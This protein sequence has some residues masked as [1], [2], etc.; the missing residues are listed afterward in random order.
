L[1]YKLDQ[2]DCGLP[3]ERRLAVPRDLGGLDV[4]APW[5]DAL[6]HDGDWP[7]QLNFAV[8]LCLEEALAN[9]IEHGA[10]PDGGPIAIVIDDSDSRRVAVRVESAGIPFDPTRYPEPVTAESLAAAKIGG[11][12]IHLMRSFTSAMRYARHDKR[13]SIELI[14]DR[15]Q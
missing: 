14:F 8:Q 15:I 11:Q 5:V 3:I 2:E 13:N 9:I 12:G 1:R 6:A 4:V 7:N 10:D